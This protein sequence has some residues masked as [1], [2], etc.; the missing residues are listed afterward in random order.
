MQIPVVAGDIGGPYT[1]PQPSQPPIVATML[2]GSTT[3]LIK[4]RSV[5]L[6]GNAV[7]SAGPI[8]SSTLNST[9]T[10]IEGLPVLLN[11]T[12]TTLASGYHSGPII[13]VVAAGVLVA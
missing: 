11:G 10:L 12:V 7:T 1:P 5:M 6:F 9:T 8:V 3:V 2:L 13:A 4:Q